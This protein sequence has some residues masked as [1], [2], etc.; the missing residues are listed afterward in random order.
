[1]NYSKD[2]ILKAVSR[3]KRRFFST[4]AISAIVSALAAAAMLIFPETTVIFFS[5][6]AIAFSVYFIIR[7]LIV[8]KPVVLFSSEICGVN[9]KEHEF[10]ITNLRPTFSARII[11]P[12][13]KTTGFTG[14]TKR[15]KP[16]TGAVVYLMLE[17]GDVAY[18]DGLTNAQTDIYEIGD[19]LYKYPG[20]RYPVI[21]GRK[22]VSQPCPLCGTANK[23][24]EPC[25]IGCGLK[26]TED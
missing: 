17:N 15:I 11:M 25:C 6:I 13:R 23:D 22:T 8:Y 16:P 24:G 5:V 2:E 7:A 18:V 10:V 9:A 20:T 19:T 1:M 4:L 3:R 14:G 21:L 12:R 26:I